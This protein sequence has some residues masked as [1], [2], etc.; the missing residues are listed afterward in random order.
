MRDMLVDEFVSGPST[1]AEEARRGGEV[2]HEVFGAEQVAELHADGHVVGGAVVLI[3]ELSPRL[4]LEDAVATGEDTEQDGGAWGGL[5]D[6]G[7]TVAMEVIAD[8]QI[9]FKTLVCEAPQGERA[10]GGAHISSDELL[11]GGGHLKVNELGRV[12]IADQEDGELRSIV[13]IHRANRIA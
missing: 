7:L 6:H 3:I 1:G 12:I 4:N 9:E 5:I 13:S 8:A 2:R 10:V 11:F